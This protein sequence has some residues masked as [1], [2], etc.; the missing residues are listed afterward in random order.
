MH[1]AAI[2]G[3]I[4]TWSDAGVRE[5]R[6]VGGAGWMVMLQTPETLLPLAMGWWSMRQ[7]TTAMVP[8]MEAKALAASVQAMR[9]IMLGQNLEA[10]TLLDGRRE[11]Q[12]SSKSRNN[13]EDLLI[14]AKEWAQPWRK[15]LVFNDEGRFAF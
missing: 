13:L 14:Q 9:A 15:R 3:N 1:T 10:S 11:T 4:V 5:T 2:T 8:R 12:M 7:R 6:A